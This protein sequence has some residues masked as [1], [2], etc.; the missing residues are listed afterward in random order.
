MPRCSDAARAICV[1]QDCVRFAAQHFGE[2]RFRERSL[3]EQYQQADCYLNLSGYEG[4]PNT[5]L[6]AMAC[7]LPVIA[8]DIPPHRRLVKHQVTGYLVD[9]E[10]PKDFINQLIKLATDRRRGRVMGE[11]GREFVLK[12]HSWTV[13]AE[14]YMALFAEGQKEAP[15]IVV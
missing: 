13:V 8:S 11:A 9:L 5:V 12:S 7:A 15:R 10:R 1:L 4:L 2:D 6:E 3:I 14:N